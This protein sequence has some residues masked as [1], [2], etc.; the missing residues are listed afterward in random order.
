[1]AAH[2]QH[3]GERR[4]DHVL[5]L[6]LGVVLARLVLVGRRL[7]VDRQ[8]IGGEREGAL[9]R[10]PPRHLPDLRVEATVLVDHDHGWPF[11]F[12]FRAHKE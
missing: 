12:G 6:G 10:K 3:G 2:E 9:D 11:T 5:A 7:A 4:R 8:E 1:V